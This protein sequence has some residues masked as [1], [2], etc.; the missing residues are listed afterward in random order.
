MRI[1]VYRTRIQPTNEAPGRAFQ[2][3][4]RAQP[5]VQAL[6]DK[7][8]VGQALTSSIGDYALYRYNMAE[9]LKLDKLS[10]EAKDRLRN[11]RFD[12]SQRQ[13]TSGIFDG[14]KPEWNLETQRIKKDILSR[15]GKNKNALQKFEATFLASESDNKFALRG[16]IAQ[17]NKTEAETVSAAKFTTLENDLNNTYNTVDDYN[18]KVALFLAEEGA[19]SET[20]EFKIK[21]YNAQR[22]IAENVTRSFISNDSA[23]ALEL[24][25]TL[26]AMMY[27]EQLQKSYGKVDGSL[28]YAQLSES[29]IATIVKNVEEA[30]LTIAQFQANYGNGAE[31]MLYTL[32]QLPEGDRNDIATKIFEEAISYED[33]VNK[34]INRQEELNTEFKEATHNNFVTIDETDTYSSSEIKNLMPIYQTN[35]FAK[36]IIDEY[37]FG[38][39]DE[40][41]GLEAQKL[42]H[43]VLKETASATQAEL[44]TMEAFFFD[45]P[46]PFF[47]KTGDPVAEQNL[48]TLQI[49]LVNGSLKLTDI[50]QQLLEKE[51][52]I[53]ETGY[54]FLNSLAESRLDEAVSNALKFAQFHYKTSDDPDT[55]NEFQLM[56]RN[57]YF[58]V[59]RDFLEVVNTIDKSTQSRTF[60]HNEMNRIMKENKVEIVAKARKSLRDQ[61]ENININNI[62]LG[63][64]ISLDPNLSTNLEALREQIRDNIGKDKVNGDKMRRDLI[65]YIEF[66]EDIMA[67]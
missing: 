52:F 37:D 53:T 29:D 20:D 24:D 67:D 28:D 12:L 51:S 56:K 60:L 3:R 42:L 19:R 47:A 46:K 30:S 48:I 16:A 9:Q 35:N 43:T 41:T 64:T 8:K 57:S 50:Q 31:Y 25:T 15:L 38:E 32:M 33:N 62:D 34:F 7:G 49:G 17:T 59:S 1:P 63:I 66:I 14:D 18:Q 40:I 36:Y 26:D 21:L 4:K 39:K 5:F 23:A 6:L 11:L 45:A 27:L 10:I 65:P 61:I 58:S 2:T 54:K 55:S 44:D 22:N 13:D